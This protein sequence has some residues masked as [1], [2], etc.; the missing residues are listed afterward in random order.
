MGSSIQMIDLNKIR[1]HPKVV[2]IYDLIAGNT[3]QGISGRLSP[4]IRKKLCQSFYPQVVEDPNHKG[5]FLCFIGLSEL[6]EL[7]NI[8]QKNISVIVFEQPL[9]FEI[10]ERS[11]LYEIHRQI[12]TPHRSEILDIVVR[13]IDLAPKDMRKLLLNSKYSYS[14]MVIVQHLTDES[15]AAIRHQRSAPPEKSELEYLLGS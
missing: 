3:P 11:W 1:V 6:I 13:C 15:R 12:S 5:H 14:S 7:K 4:Y 10:F 8:D 2:G 9:D